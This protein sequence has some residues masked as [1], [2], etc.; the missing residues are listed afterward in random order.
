VANTHL[1]DIRGVMFFVSGD[2]PLKKSGYPKA[3][4]EAEESKREV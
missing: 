4:I 1:D 2:L 3:T